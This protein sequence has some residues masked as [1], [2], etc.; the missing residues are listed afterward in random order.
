MKMTLKLV[1]PLLFVV[2]L[3]ACQ[4][5]YYSTMEKLGQHKRDILVSKVEDANESQ[6]EAQQEF[7]SALEGLSALINFDGGKL[8]DYYNQTKDHYEASAEAAADVS[9]RIEAI[10]SVA[11]ALFDEWEDE[12][13]QFSNA[14]L[15]RQSKLQLNE[16]KRKYDKVIRSMHRAESSMEPVLAA[17][18][19]NT[20][21]LKHNL[22]AQAIGA[23][24][25]E[26]KTIQK[27]I[28]SLIAEMN[29]AIDS[30]KQ[31]IANLKTP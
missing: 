16:T 11:G 4:S 9:K 21:Y 2:S 6:E 13:T 1:F 8:E 23:L 24:E 26:Y 29:V 31:F 22:N 10:E 5:A 3:G 20:L 30:S 12:I 14:K 28:T 18:K 7:T 25:G 15:Q 19:D 27:D 17:L